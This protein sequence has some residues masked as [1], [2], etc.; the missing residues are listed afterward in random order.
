M[1]KSHS[2]E[3]CIFEILERELDSSNRSVTSVYVK[4]GHCGGFKV[5]I[6]FKIEITSVR[7]LD[8]AWS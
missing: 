8:G 1:Y 3:I 5:E 2:F 7:E 6:T 4:K